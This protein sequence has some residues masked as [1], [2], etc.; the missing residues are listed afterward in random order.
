M[1]DTKSILLDSYSKEVSNVVIFVTY[2][3]HIISQIH[4][5]SLIQNTRGPVNPDKRSTPLGIQSNMINLT[6][7]EFT[8]HNSVAHGAAHKTNYYFV[9]CLA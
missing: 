2:N 9:S 4:D 1:Y 3:S 6:R 8:Y 5:K 7:L